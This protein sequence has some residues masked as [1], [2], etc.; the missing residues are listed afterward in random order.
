VRRTREGGA[1][2]GQ[3]RWR[4]R[5]CYSVGRTTG[6]CG[7]RAWR[8]R[9]DGALPGRERA[10]VPGRD[11]GRRRSAMAARDGAG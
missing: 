6:R 8:D 4:S 2:G 9:R 1:A 10:N 3:T 11:R 5:G 7:L